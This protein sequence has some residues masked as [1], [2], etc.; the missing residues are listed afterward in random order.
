[1]VNRAK[2]FLV[3]GIESSLVLHFPSVAVSLLAGSDV[4]ASG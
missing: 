2:R 3:Y 4:V 1:M